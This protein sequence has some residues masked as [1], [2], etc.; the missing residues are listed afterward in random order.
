MKP[1][2]HPA[3]NEHHRDLWL[4]QHVHHAQHVPDR[5]S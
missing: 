4:R 3:Y 5:F 1:D 2:I